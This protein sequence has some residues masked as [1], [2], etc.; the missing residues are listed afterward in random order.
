MNL[1]KL[2]LKWIE[3]N[4][5]GTSHWQFWSKKGPTSNNIYYNDYYY[6]NYSD[7]YNN[8]KVERPLLGLLVKWVAK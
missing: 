3:M 8:T 4:W 7:L 5:H 6:N 2:K 1:N